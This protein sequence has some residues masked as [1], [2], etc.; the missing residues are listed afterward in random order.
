MPAVVTVEDANLFECFDSSLVTVTIMSQ[1][2]GRPS[3][4]IGQEF[5]TKVA[6]TLPPGIQITYLGL[7]ATTGLPEIDYV[8]ADRSA[9]IFIAAADIV[10]V[11]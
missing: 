2:L 8:I 7:P 11:L 3:G 10:R 6:G 5:Q 9:V 1:A 4:S